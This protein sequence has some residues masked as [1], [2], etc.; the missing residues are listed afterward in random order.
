[1]NS[2]LSQITSRLLRRNRAPAAPLAVNTIETELTTQ[3]LI[4]AAI[5]VLA[6]RLAPLRAFSRDFGVR[7][8]APLTTYQVPIATAGPAVQTDA[9]DFESGNSTLD[10]RPVEVHHYTASFHI[11]NTEFQ[12][13]QRIEML[14]GIAAANLADKIS[15]VVTALM[16]AGTYGAATNIGLAAAFGAG[17][18]AA[19]LTLAKDYPKSSLLLD[20]GHL[21]YLLPVDKTSFKIGEQGAFGF[22][23]IAAQNRWTSAEA[24]ACG[25]VCSPAAIAVCAGV[26]ATAPGAAGAGLTSR[27]FTIPG[28]ELTVQHNQW[29]NTGTRALWNSFDVMFGAGV[30]DETAGRILVSAT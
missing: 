20:G 16:V 1:M 9:S 15:D 25:F 12:N 2:A 13:G 7:T 14:A 5:T 4:P 6:N 30:G 21:A 8:M 26:P 19:V 24:N 18:L 28:L 17:D 11:A 27:T 22:D 3:H 23:L 29:L 10:H